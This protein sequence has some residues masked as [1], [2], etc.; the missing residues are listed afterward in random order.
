M[1]SAPAAHMAM[2]PVAAAPVDIELRLRLQQV[3]RRTP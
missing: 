3:F 2:L 1:V